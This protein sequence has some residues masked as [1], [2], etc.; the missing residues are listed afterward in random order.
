[1]NSQTFEAPKP[2]IFA[3]KQPEQ[4]FQRS[5]EPLTSRKDG[6]AQLTFSGYKHTVRNDGNG[7]F[8]QIVFSVMDITQKNPAN[9][10]INSNYKY[11]EG[12]LL[13]RLL[14][15]MGYDHQ[16]NIIV[17]DEN[18]EFGYTINEDLNLIYVFLESQKGLMFKGFCNLEENNKGQ[19]WYRI[20]VDSLEPLMD[21]IGTQKRAYDASEG[22]SENELNIDIVARG[23]DDN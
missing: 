12:N 10:C 21:K 20:K 15:L 14:K 3:P 17:T 23:G 8:L 9:I 2:S 11:S 7:A 18:D 6:K 22:L 1:M 13:G 5:F 16:K 19:W 4:N